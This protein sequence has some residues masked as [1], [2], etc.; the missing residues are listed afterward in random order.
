MFH[1]ADDVAD[2][3][4][5]LFGVLDETAVTVED[6]VAFVQCEIPTTMVLKIYVSR[7]TWSQMARNHVRGVTQSNINKAMA[8]HLS[9]RICSTP[10]RPRCARLKSLRK[11]GY[12]LNLVL[13]IAADQINTKIYRRAPMLRRLRGIC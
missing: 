2:L 11:H 12:F 5:G 1:D 3:G 7:Y 8:A 13:D 10:L 4:G 9:L 6:D